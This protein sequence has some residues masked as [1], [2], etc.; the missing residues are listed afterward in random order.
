M[1]GLTMVTTIAVFARSVQASTD[2]SLQRGL[3]AQV[4]VTPAAGSALPTDLAPHLAASPELT[5]VTALTSH[6][7][8]IDPGQPARLGGSVKA[9]A[10][11]AQVLAYAR[12]V[13]I[14]PTAGRL[15]AVGG[16]RVAVTTGIAQTWHLSVGSPLQLGSS[17]VADRTFSVAAI[18]HDPTGMTGDILFSPSGL[19]LLFPQVPAPVT[20][21][22]AQPAPGTNPGSALAAA[23]R[24]VL[25][26]SWSQRQKSRASILVAW[27]QGT[28]TA[29]VNRNQRSSASAYDRCVVAGRPAACRSLRNSDTGPTR[30]PSGSLT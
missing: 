2:G 13:S 24:P 8:F 23:G 15:A 17:Q 4:I 20:V 9:G 6:G 22:L 7:V 27:F 11:G 29:Q 1:I 10:T 25:P 19:N 30:P 12:D 16:A 5:D 28:S 21:V 18:I 3:L 26:A 14:P